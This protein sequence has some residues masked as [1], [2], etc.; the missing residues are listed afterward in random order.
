MA[1]KRIPQLDALTGA[2]S[3]ND[4]NLVIF[5]TSADTTKRI[6]RSQLAIGMATDLS[7]AG[8]ENDGTGKI[9][10]I[11]GS[12][13][14]SVATGTGLTGGPITD[15]GTVSLANT[16][17]T[18]GSYGSAS[19][20]GTFTVDA[21]GRITA[22]A[23]TAI[24]VAIPTATETVQGIVELATQAEALAGTDTVR[25]VTPDG[26]R[27]VM[28]RVQ[29]NSQSAAYTLV[30]ADA[31]RHIYHPAADAT[32]RVW[33]IPANASVAFPIGTAL[34]FIN[35]GGT[36]TLSIT[37]DTLVLA[38]DGATGSRTL[39]Q[40]GMATAVKVTSTRWMI[41]GSGLT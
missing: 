40:Y 19:Q 33:T 7:G 41:S 20:V 4:D 25:A 2:A 13:V 28:E 34:T 22:A 18:P 12:R 24:S 21:Q 30:L 15:T 16:A 29:Q 10:V 38:G 39:A 35:D 32:A 1:N 27:A 23:N 17:V 8:L 9:R 5:D 31:G 26:A 37:S 36:I 11:P 14:T 3:A 6:L